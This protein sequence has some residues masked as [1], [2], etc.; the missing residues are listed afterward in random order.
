MYI[1]VYAV[2]CVCLRMIFNHLLLRTV[3]G[4]TCFAWTSSMAVTFLAFPL[5]SSLV[6]S[7]SNLTIFVYFVYTPLI[8]LTYTYIY[9]AFLGFLR[10]SVFK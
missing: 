1:L 9:K 2:W 4:I 5:V 7:F 10:V 8:W 3:F 6:F